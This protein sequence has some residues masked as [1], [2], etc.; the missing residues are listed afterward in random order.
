MV[1][2]YIKPDLEFIKHLKS[3]GGNTVKKCFQC[4]TCSV[5]CPQAP[6]DNPFPR[7][8][9]IWAQWG[10]KDRL[11]RDPDVWICHYCGDCS[12]HCPRG[13]K[14]GEVLN[15][16]R[17]QSISY[18]STPGSL[19]N[20][21]GNKAM[22]PVLFL[23]PA[24]LFFG[25][26]GMKWDIVSGITNKNDIIFA[27]VF[28]QMT[29][30]DPLFGLLAMFILFSVGG[31][32]LKMWK[33]MKSTFPPVKKKSFVGAAISTIIDIFTHSK[34]YDCAVNRD[35]A[36]AHRLTFYGFVLLFITTMIIAAAE[37][38]HILAKVDFWTYKEF[39][40]HVVSVT[41]MELSNPAK[42]LGNVGAIVLL[43]GITLITMNRFKQEE[44]GAY[45]DWLLII[46]IFGLVL[47][48]IL[49]EVARLAGTAV[50]AYSIYAVHLIFIFVLFAYLPFSKLAHM[51]YRTVALVYLE[52]SGRA[53]PV[54]LVTEK[55]EEE[56]A[57]PEGEAE[58]RAEEAPAE[59]DAKVEEEKPKDTT[60]PPPP[61][62]PGVPPPP[63]PSGGGGGSGAP[64]PPPT[65]GVPP[66]PP[67]PPG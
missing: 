55:A 27:K 61:P 66:P 10:L 24:I 48:G 19:T 18:F 7:K 4:A 35:R 57:E 16:I 67:P 33:E 20:V 17:Q 28:P 31:G 51:F 41:P 65:P 15:S 64:P 39:G 14:P 42:I 29:F 43:A 8:E 25:M 44:K 46:T 40:D 13:A 54:V 47:T 34:F 1:D 38:V 36:L 62:T 37:W 23:I 9:M 50:G 2:E 59:D 3:S 60:T 63:P 6:E 22:L 26:L 12:T 52:Y 49:T 53:E 56:A 58:A 5:V 45:F 30:I 21:V 32:C 11:L